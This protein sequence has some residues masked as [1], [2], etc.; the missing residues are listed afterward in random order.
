MMKRHSYTYFWRRSTLGALAALLWLT[1][2]FAQ[3][4][5]VDDPGWFGGSLA[6][7]FCLTQSE[8][9][10]EQAFDR[11]L[12]WFD[13][14]GGP[15][16]LHCSAVAL[17]ALGHFGDAA[18]RLD[19]LGQDPANGLGARLRAEIFV[20]AASAWMLEGFPLQAVESLE[21]AL[22][23]EAGDQRLQMEIY[24]DRARAFVMDDNWGAAVDDLNR[25]LDI[26]PYAH[27]ALTLRATGYR[28]LGEVGL[29]QEDLSR[30]LT[31]DPDYAPALLERGVLW[32]MLSDDDAARA[33]WIR[34]LQLEPEGELGD[35]ARR[36]LYDLDFP[37]GL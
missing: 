16:A 34:V 6:Y 15:P 33:D 22:A 28:A 32:R 8:T 24:F 9:D 36:H 13:Q 12:D 7:Q 19:A 26:A 27:D 10:P 29:A 25:V 18:D 37:D 5:Q 3:D 17:V 4:D 20:Q 35:A 21:A 11:A 30:V 23:L 31:D 1:P 14:G 2:A